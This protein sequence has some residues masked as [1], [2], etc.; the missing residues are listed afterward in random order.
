MEAADA[1]RPKADP[2]ET[3]QLTGSSRFAF[4][5]HPG[6][7]C[8]TQC[9]RTID[10]VLSP[11][12]VLRLTRRLGES[13]E[14]FLERRTRTTLHPQSGLPVVVLRTDETPDGA[15]QFLGDAGCT[16]YTDR[17]MVCRYY[18]VGVGALKVRKAEKGEPSEERFFFMVRE[19]HCRGFEEPMEWTV[20]EWIADQGA[21]EYEA[22]NADWLGALLRR[23]Q[24]GGET[25]ELRLQSLF[26]LASYNLDAFRAFVFES[27]FLEMFEI[28]EQE[29]ARMREND[30]ALLA[31][32]LRYLKWALGLEE[33]M[34]LKASPA[35]GKP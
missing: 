4:R 7:S 9:C 31:F 27:R 5:C 33:T 1:P 6:I 22:A 30:E 35:P 23:S 28:D 26:Y 18:P 8:F 24:P 29:V 21:A 17:P 19:P 34:K 10:V 32:G 12:D 25:P 20:E 15:C 16:V 3:V 11:H 14:A 13:S 2:V